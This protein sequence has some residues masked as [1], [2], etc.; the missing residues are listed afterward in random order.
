MAFCATKLFYNRLFSQSRHYDDCKRIRL[1]IVELGTPQSKVLDEIT[2]FYRYMLSSLNT[3]YS[4]DQGPPGL[5]DPMLKG[6]NKF[7]DDWTT[8]LLSLQLP[9]V[10]GSSPVHPLGLGTPL[11]DQSNV[12]SPYAAH[13]STP[14]S[15][16]LLKRPSVASLNPAPAYSPI[17]VSSNN[18]QSFVDKC[19]QL[20]L[21]RLNLYSLIRKNDPTLREYLRS[22]MVYVPLVIMDFIDFQPQ[23]VSLYF[24]QFSIEFFKQFQSHLD[25]PFKITKFIRN[26]RDFFIGRKNIAKSAIQNQPN[27]QI[28]YGGMKAFLAEV[29]QYGKD[30]LDKARAKL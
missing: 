19:R 22:R 30:A 20:H 23:L 12:W 11:Q 15:A 2:G 8:L 18:A 28:V 6:L 27:K 21:D 24:D 7:I 13:S 16:Y 4:S 17:L 10:Q 1:E 9:N 3:R 26:Y 25:R 29:N 14:R 5:L